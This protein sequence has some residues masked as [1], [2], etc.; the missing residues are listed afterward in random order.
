MHNGERIAE[1]SKPR[2]GLDGDHATTM[3]ENSTL[4]IVWVSA[5]PEGSMYNVTF[6]GVCT[7]TTAH[8]R[9]CPSI[10]DPSAWTRFSGVWSGDHGRDEDWGGRSVK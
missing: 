4:M 8:N 3:A 2:E 7:T 6:E 5:V 10:M 1:D 9:E